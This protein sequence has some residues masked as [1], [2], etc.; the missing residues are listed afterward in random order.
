MLGLCITPDFM[1]SS[2]EDAELNPPYYRS[3]LYELAQLPIL[4][5]LGRPLVVTLNNQCKEVGN[6]WSGWNNAVLQLCEINKQLGTNQL[7]VLQAGN[8]FDLYWNENGSVP[9]EFG[10]DLA[11][12]TARIAHNYDIKIA[13]TSVAGP[14][15]PEYL[16]TMA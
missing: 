10:A 4:Y 12:R 11:L 9:P 14:R 8:E 6:D 1:P 2:T 3:I 7:L 15:W 16:Q 13:A 5:T